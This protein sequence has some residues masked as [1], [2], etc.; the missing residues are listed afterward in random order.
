LPHLLRLLWQCLSW[1]GSP[2]SL[3]P[4]FSQD[5]S[6][7]LP[8]ISL[9]AAWGFLTNAALWLVFDRF[10]AQ[11]LGFSAWIVLLTGA[12]FHYAG[13]ALMLAIALLLQQNTADKWAKTAA[14]SVLVGVVLT[15]TGITTTQIGLPH[16]IETVAGAAMALAATGA[17]VVF[18]RASRAEVRATRW[19]WLLGG[20]CLF[21]TMLLALLYALRPVFPLFWLNMPLMQA[22]H[23]SV[24]ALGFGTLMLLG[25]KFKP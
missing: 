19:L 3:R 21:G 1:Q 6:F 13:F 17:G 11:P 23:G 15:A 7:S 22:V 8:F 18:I 16:W 2:F 12:H 20:L 5:S 10:D 4:P 24:N 9:L 25:W 14:F